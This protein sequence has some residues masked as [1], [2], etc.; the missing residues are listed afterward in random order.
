MIGVVLI[1]V[2]LVGLPACDDLKSTS[3]PE[4]GEIP[5]V[6]L[7]TIEREVSTLFVSVGQSVTLTVT[8]SDVGGFYAVRDDLNA[9]E[10]VSHTADNYSDGVFIMLEQ[11]PFSYTVTVSQ[12]LAP[13]HEFS[14]AGQWWTD[15]G[16]S[17]PMPETILS[18]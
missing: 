8:P 9:L 4:A 6:Q 14:I 3:E 2:M 1:A 15:P 12:C 18:C 7:G 10:L 5:P 13:G 11:K 17:H 16:Q